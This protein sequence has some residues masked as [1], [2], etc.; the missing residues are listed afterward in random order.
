MED[1]FNMLS[2]SA[3]IDKSKRKSKPI[4]RPAAIITKPYA[5]NEQSQQQDDNDSNKT[6]KKQHSAEK[7]QQ[8]H[9]EEISAFRRRMGI[10]LSNDNRHD[11]D[12][13]DPISSFREWSCP[14]WWGRTDSGETLMNLIAVT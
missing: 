1:L 11:E 10:K 5:N 7:L 2:S 6:K 14:K 4:V 9:K 8:I 3:R 12:V 13:P